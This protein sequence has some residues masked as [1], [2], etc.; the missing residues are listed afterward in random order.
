LA[1]G[2]RKQLSNKELRQHAFGKKHQNKLGEVQEVA[3]YQSV[4]QQQWPGTAER[5]TLKTA[6]LCSGG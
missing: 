6:R 5:L 4:K 2:D 3:V 1:V